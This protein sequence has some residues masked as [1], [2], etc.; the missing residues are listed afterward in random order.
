M[1]NKKPKNY[2]KDIGEWSYEKVP[3]A[4]ILDGEK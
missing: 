3:K 4:K 2:K 1:S